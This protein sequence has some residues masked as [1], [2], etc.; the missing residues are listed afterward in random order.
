ML[1]AI[2]IGIEYAYAMLSVTYDDVQYR[3]E[4]I[5]IQAIKE[6]MSKLLFIMLDND[7]LIPSY[8]I[9]EFGNR[10]AEDSN[11][12]IKF[13]VYEYDWLTV[14][15]TSPGFI[16][17]QKYIVLDTKLKKNSLVFQFVLLHE[18]GHGMDKALVFNSMLFSGRNNVSEIFAD[19]YAYNML[20]KEHSHDQICQAFKSCTSKSEDFKVRLRAMQ[21]H[22]EGY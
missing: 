14:W 4:Y 8:Y 17:N 10:L 20:I 13:N 6:N 7:E 12:L 3:N 21:N 18:I 5:K 2:F 16:L 15:H 19:K 1:T 11:A 22:Y 9:D